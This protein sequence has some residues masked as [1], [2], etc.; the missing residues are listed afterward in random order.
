MGECFIAEKKGTLARRQYEK[1]VPKLNQHDDSKLF[2]EV[3]YRLGRLCED[4]SDAAA[5]ED[6]YGEVLVV[7]YD[8][9]DT[10]TRL[11]NLQGG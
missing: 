6:H 11:E 8:Y 10:R 5:A 3:H 7:D 4:A 2:L 9:K 1:A